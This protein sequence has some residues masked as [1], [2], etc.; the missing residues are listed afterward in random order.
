MRKIWLVF[1]FFLAVSLT[2]CASTSF[3]GYQADGRYCFRISKRKVCT[4]DPVP[5]VEAEAKA[6]QFQPLPDRQVVWLVRNAHLDPVGKVS[7]SVNGMKVEMLPFTVSRFELAPGSYQIAATYRSNNV[8]DITAT[9]IAGEQQFVEVFADV[10]LFDTYFSLR[11]IS[12]VEGRR[13]V[14]TGKLIADVRSKDFAGRP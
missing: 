5:S 7:V 9:G 2:G 1:G 11:A 14:S 3:E 4:A 8:G 13:K 10:G 12:N 6:K